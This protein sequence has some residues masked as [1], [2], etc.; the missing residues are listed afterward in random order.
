MN[1]R[2]WTHSRK[3]GHV[4]SVMRPHIR[5]PR[6]NYNTRIFLPHV[7]ACNQPFFT[8]LRTKTILMAVSIHPLSSLQNLC[9]CRSNHLSPLHGVRH[10]KLERES[11]K[12]GSRGRH[13]VLASLCPFPIG[14]SIQLACCALH[15]NP[16]STTGLSCECRIAGFNV[17]N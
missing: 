11:F 7:H 10:C 13:D 5:V 2:G 14:S 12:G 16:F 4:C 6:R 17:R 9:K 1:G 8:L 3:C 15:L